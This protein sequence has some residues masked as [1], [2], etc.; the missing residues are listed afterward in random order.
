DPDGRILSSGHREADVDSPRDQPGSAAYVDAVARAGERTRGTIYLLTLAA[1]VMFAALRL[2]ISPGWLQA[3]LDKLSYAY[4]CW[5]D[6]QW[7]ASHATLCHVATKY[8]IE[9][10]LCLEGTGG[11]TRPLTDDE[12]REIV[13]EYA[14]KAIDLR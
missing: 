14:K 11:C 9:H 8:A 7:E 1:L 10:G 2:T 5:N 6:A 4:R 13:R 3:R 12:Y